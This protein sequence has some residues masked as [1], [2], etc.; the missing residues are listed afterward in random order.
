MSR[1]R[2]SDHQGGAP[3]RSRAEELLLSL[4]ELH[5]HLSADVS[6]REAGA[7]VLRRGM[8]AIGAAYGT[9]RVLDSLDASVDIVELGSRSSVPA[10]VAEA[11]ELD[12][13]AWL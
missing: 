13:A 5:D 6:P 10:A 8:A 2:D 11:L 1:S 3:S 7:R 4:A 12:G 9:A